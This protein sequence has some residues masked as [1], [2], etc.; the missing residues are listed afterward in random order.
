MIQ[1]NA[2]IHNTAHTSLSVMSVVPGTPRHRISRV[3][4]LFLFLRITDD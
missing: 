4:P 3:K 2:P 1:N